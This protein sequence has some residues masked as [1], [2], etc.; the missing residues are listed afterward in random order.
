MTSK[1]GKLVL[2]ETEG[3]AKFMQGAKAAYGMVTGTFGPKGKNIRL[4]KIFGRAI[5]TRDGVTVAREVYFSDRAKNLGAQA[6]L[7]ASETTNRVAG[8]GTTATVGLAYQLLRQ[9]H[10]A[11]AAGIHPMEIAETYR[12]DEKIILDRLDELSKPVTGTKPDKDGKLPITS[13]VV[14]VATVSSGSPVL[15]QLIAESIARVGVDGGVMVEKAPLD[16]IEREY[17]DGYYVQSG[18]QA[19]VGGKKEMLEPLVMVFNKRIASASDIGD[20]LGKAAAARGLE[21]G[22]DI[23]K[24]LLIGNV[25]SAAYDQVVALLN[26]RQIDAIIL[27]APPHFG[28]MGKDLLEDIAIYC[29]C[30]SISE[31]IKAKQIGLV[32][33]GSVDRVVAT[34]YDATLFAEKTAER[35]QV[36]VDE[37]KDQIKAESNDAIL[38][39][40]RDRVAKL[41]GKIALFKI[42]AATETEKEEKEFRVDDALQ[43]TRAAIR[44]GVVAGGGVTLLELAKTDISSYYKNALLGT[45]K[46]LFTNAAPGND[47]VL[48]DAALKFPIGHG[49]NLRSD[50]HE[51]VDMVKEGI[52]DPKLVISEVIKNATSVGAENLK[53]G[54]TSI[55]EDAPLEKE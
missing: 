36:R 34:K 21:P 14:Q 20:I 25:E 2:S 7:E 23:F 37:L 42:G 13:Q 4:E 32:H 17:I 40:L 51:P 1:E 18:F 52:I 26:K 30:A 31:G 3:N 49:F 24:F 43:A 8:D 45:V 27:K 54:A 50:D 22:R 44:H 35:V 12:K 15:G 5:L 11:I 29:G 16:N 39:R 10:Q 55:F 6:L 38:E 46:Q 47:Q 41:D 19:L 48:L 33:I 53:V 28:D 9:G